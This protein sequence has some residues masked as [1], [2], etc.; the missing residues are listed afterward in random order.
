VDASKQY[1]L[2]LLYHVIDED[3]RAASVFEGASQEFDLVV[4]IYSG[5]SK[6]T[7]YA[8]K[9]ADCTSND[10]RL[11]SPAGYIVSLN[12]D[13]DGKTAGFPP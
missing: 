6:V 11:G 1:A 12:L 3:V 13:A 2:V 4:A 7:A 5:S 10:C 9:E 8:V